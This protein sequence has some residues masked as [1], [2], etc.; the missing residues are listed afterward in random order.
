MEIFRLDGTNFG[1]AKRELDSFSFD[2]HIIYD[3]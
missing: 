2:I 3:V 1:S